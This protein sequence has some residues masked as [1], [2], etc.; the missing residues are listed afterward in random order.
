[1]PPVDEAPPPGLDP[2]ENPIV[3]TPTIDRSVFSLAVLVILGAIV[4]SGLGLLIGSRARTSETVSGL[5]NLVMLPMWLLGGAFFS[6]ARFPD[7]IQPLV[8][9]IPLSHLTDAMRTVAHGGG[10]VDC[11]PAVAVLAGFAITFFV[12]SLK[13]FRWN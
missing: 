3:P 2:E 10:W 4:F 5:M 9:A 6:H 8:Q 12:L 13:L 7:T 11:G 1:M